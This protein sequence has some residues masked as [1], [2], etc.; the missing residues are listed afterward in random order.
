M[1]GI[2]L[3]LLAAAFTAVIL[4]P[5]GA[6]RGD[7]CRLCEAA[8]SASNAPKGPDTPISIDI[9]TRLNFSRFA[10]A[11]TGQ[12]GQVKINPQSG[13]AQVQGGLVDLGGYSLAGTAVIRGEPGR[14]VRVDMPAS[15]QMTSSTGGTMTLAELQTDLG[16]APRLDASGELRFS[17]GGALQVSGSV[18]GKFRGRIPITAQY[19]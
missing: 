10:M 4:L 3:S 11:G 8:P 16:P 6:A 13:T 5:I 1:I 19:E 17:F 14:Q 12:S 2:R 15:I 9:T 7:V 18:S